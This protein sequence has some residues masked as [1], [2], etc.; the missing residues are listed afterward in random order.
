MK[1]R[2][3][4]AELKKQELKNVEAEKTE[5]KDEDLDGVTGGLIDHTK[6]EAFLFFFCQLRNIFILSFRLYPVG[7]AHDI[8][9]C[10]KH[11]GNDKF[12]YRIGVGTGGVKYHDTVISTFC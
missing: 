12:L 3:K 8:T 7:T 9:G 5:I 2:E 6:Q 1:K 11:S 4:G 10:Q